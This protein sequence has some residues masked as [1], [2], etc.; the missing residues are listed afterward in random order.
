MHDCLELQCLVDFSEMSL[1]ISASLPYIII[2]CSWYRTQTW[3]RKKTL[4]IIYIAFYQKL[5]QM[6]QTND[7]LHLWKTGTVQRKITVCEKDDRL[8]Y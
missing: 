1:F 6:A 5:W 4:D 8:S 3:K 2:S 7:Y